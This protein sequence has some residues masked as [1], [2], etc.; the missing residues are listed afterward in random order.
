MSEQQE[1]VPAVTVQA[2]VAEVGTAEE[3]SQDNQ[4]ENDDGM[5]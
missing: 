2:G 1:E 4:E 3:P 5:D